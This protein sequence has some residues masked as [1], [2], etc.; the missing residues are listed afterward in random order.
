MLPV[1]SFKWTVM[2]NIAKCSILTRGRPTAKIYPQHQ[3]GF[4]ALVSLKKW[5]W[6][7]NKLLYFQEQN[8]SFRIPL[9][10]ALFCYCTLFY[11]IFTVCCVQFQVG[12][13]PVKSHTMTTYLALLVLKFISLFNLFILFYFTLLLNSLI[14]YCFLSETWKSCHMCSSV[15]TSC[16]QKHHITMFWFILYQ[17]HQMLANNLARADPK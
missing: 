17:T 4:E 9:F 14:L 1:A 15:A 2:L 8:V 3:S 11:V 5:Y 6:I 12:T 10:G 7:Y 16:N 13:I